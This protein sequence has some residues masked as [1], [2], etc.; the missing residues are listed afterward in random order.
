VALGLFRIQGLQK[1]EA[2]DGPRWSNW[3]KK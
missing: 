3:G 1:S 2:Q